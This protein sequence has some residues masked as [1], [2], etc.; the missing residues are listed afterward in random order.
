MKFIFQILLLLFS[1]SGLAA[2]SEPI[3]LGDAPTALQQL[4]E[5]LRTALVAR[6]ADSIYQ[7]LAANYYIKRDFG[8]TFDQNASPAE[9]FSWAYQFNN[10]RLRP[11][12]KGKRSTNHVLA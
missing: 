7:S 3:S 8:G 9:N 11:E 6:D 2:E 5:K 10:S 4:I 12:Y 1:S